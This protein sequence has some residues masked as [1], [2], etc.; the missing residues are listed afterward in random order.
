MPVAKHIVGFNLH[1]V[2]S[3]YIK[4]AYSY[5]AYGRLEYETVTR[6]AG[7]TTNLCQTQYAYSRLAF[8]TQLERIEQT[9]SGGAWAN[10][11]KTQYQWDTLGRQAFEERFDYSGGLWLNRYDITQRR[12]NIRRREARF[13]PSGWPLSAGAKRD[14]ASAANGNITQVTERDTRAGGAL[15]YGRFCNPCQEPVATA[16]IPGLSNRLQGMIPGA[17]QAQAAQRHRVSHPVSVR[18]GRVS[19]RVSI[20]RSHLALK[21]SL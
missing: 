4:T 13:E 3:A 1:Q 2:S 21:L 15:L 10:S 20:G 18:P 8:G 9:Y 7:G 17:A 12:R 5:D 6:E 16:Q 11:Y 19:A 14:E